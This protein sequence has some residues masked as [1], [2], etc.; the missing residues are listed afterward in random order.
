M[1]SRSTSLALILSK[2]ACST[3]HHYPFAPPQKLTDRDR[4]CRAFPYGGG[5][6]FDASMTHVACRKDP[7]NAGLE[8]Q[9]LHL[10]QLFRISD[11]MA[12]Q[13][14]TILVELYIFLEKG[15][16]RHLADED[17]CR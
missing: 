16:I 17:E 7:G 11:V 5:D 1:A 13:Q 3:R 4:G 12:R 2:D 8:G 14:E 9:R 6:P 15:G 10:Q